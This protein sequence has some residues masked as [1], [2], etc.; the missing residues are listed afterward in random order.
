MRHTLVT[1]ALGVAVLAVLDWVAWLTAEGPASG[2]DLRPD[3]VRVIVGGTVFLAVAAAVA[4]GVVLLLRWG[5]G[6]RETKTEV[7]TP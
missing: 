4:C 7:K 3:P 1:V 6:R 5:L 2:A